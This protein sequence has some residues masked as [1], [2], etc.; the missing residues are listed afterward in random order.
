M[1]QVSAIVRSY[2]LS[3]ER[4][5]L[6][7][8]H[9]SARDPYGKAHHQGPTTTGDDPSSDRTLR[10]AAFPRK[11]RNTERNEGESE[12]WREWGLVTRVGAR[13]ESGFMMVGMFS[14]TS[15]RALRR[16]QSLIRSCRG[17]V[18]S[19]T[20]SVSPRSTEINDPVR[21]RAKEGDV[22]SGRDD[23]RQTVNNEP[24]LLISEC[25]I[26]NLA[27][28][29]ALPGLWKIEIFKISVPGFMGRSRRWFSITIGDSSPEVDN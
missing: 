20:R 28:I 17:C 13:V 10:V 11:D 4:I 8:R 7:Y 9:P 1:S 19:R 5:D 6:C 14:V 29:N 12:A 2:A 3:V 27:T 23:D 26:F 21:R 18:P 25:T 22:A 24:S 15:C 16:L